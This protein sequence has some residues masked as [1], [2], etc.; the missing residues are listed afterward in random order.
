MQS[1]I[2]HGNRRLQICQPLILSTFAPPTWRAVPARGIAS[3]WNCL[4]GL[5]SL[6]DGFAQLNLHRLKSSCLQLPTHQTG[7]RHYTNASKPE[8]GLAA[9]A[10]VVTK[11]PE[12]ETTT[13][14]I[15]ITFNG[16]QAK[17]S[18]QAKLIR[19]NFSVRNRFKRAPRPAI[20]GASMTR[21]EP[22]LRKSGIPNYSEL[23]F[24]RMRSSPSIIIHALKRGRLTTK[25]RNFN[26]AAWS[27]ENSAT[28]K[29]VRHLLALK[30]AEIASLRTQAREAGAY[31]SNPDASSSGFK[32]N[33]LARLDKREYTNED[34]EQ[35]AKIALA[36]AKVRM[37]LYL[38]SNSAVPPQAIFN[39]ALRDTTP[40]VRTLR[41]L[42]TSSKLTL[43]FFSERRSLTEAGNMQDNQFI[44]I[45]S[46]LM[47]HARRIAPSMLPKSIAPLVIEYCKILQLQ[48]I[49]KVRLSHRLHKICNA[50]V[51]RL[52]ITP[53]RQPME[54]MEYA[55]VAQA[56]IL[57]LGD[58]FSPGLTLDAPTYRAII[59]V[60]LAC[61]KTDW[62][63]HAVTHLHRTWPPWRRTHDG[64][65]ARIQ[66]DDELS[67]VVSVV[68]NLIRA[69]HPKTSFDKMAMIL[70]GR[71]VDGTPTIPTRTLLKARYDKSAYDPASKN[72]DLEWA[73]R[74]RATRDIRE[75]WGA[76][77]AC[78]K[79][80]LKPTQ[81]M[82]EEMIEK[83][84]YDTKREGG[85]R[86]TPRIPGAGREVAIYRNDNLSE[87][88]LL[89]VNPPNV[90]ELLVLMKRNG[91]R[92]SEKSL[93]LLIRGA[94]SPRHAR[95]LMLQ[96]GVD[97]FAVLQL[98][99]GR[100]AQNL[101]SAADKEIIPERIMTAYIQLLCRF[102]AYKWVSPSQHSGRTDGKDYLLDAIHIL[103]RAPTY[104]VA[105][106]T[107]VK[108]I[109]LMKKSKRDETYDFSTSVR[110]WMLLHEV[111]QHR[112]TMN[113]VDEDT[114]GYACY[115]LYNAL[116]GTR[117]G[118]P[119][120]TGV[121][122]EGIAFINELW[123]YITDAPAE[124]RGDT[125][126][127]TLLHEIKGW[128]LHAYVRVLARA[129]Q[130]SQIASL[131]SWITHHE[132]ELDAIALNRSNG[133]TGLRR[134]LVAMRVYA[135]STRD[136]EFEGSL[137][138]MADSIP[139]DWGGWPTDGECDEYLDYTSEAEGMRDI[140][141]VRLGHG[142]IERGGEGMFSSAENIVTEE[143]SGPR[144]SVEPVGDGT[145][146]YRPM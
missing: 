25:A 78:E 16:R 85:A 8:D 60:L 28:A 66:P 128:Q 56:K 37:L 137:R 110:L 83:L 76:F 54:N 88:E 36:P 6:D 103:K 95:D 96:N 17:L 102:S 57:E 61:K 92:L 3:K 35:W 43:M 100:G 13:K 5:V 18:P 119:M 22:F 116:E 93:C 97:K 24:K 84:V 58:T 126:H 39:E 143:R 104:R 68:R 118:Y 65:D 86:P 40:D 12:G 79:L 42:I 82:F 53:E 7:T 140:E 109:A 108:T 15:G 113:V 59:K 48:E 121:K 142:I 105:W 31:I 34:I 141:G 145:V 29:L 1:R 123:S 50:A 81:G 130:K 122:N 44:T 144:N 69:G 129:G 32:E 87:T 139:Q 89:R 94:H 127:P 67:R 74:V 80:G 125:S 55:W 23:Q 27:K 134:T 38:N 99:R 120:E 136:S 124:E 132:N 4:H 11:A 9:P 90:D 64:M 41:K 106:H 138:D 131:L 46:T 45:F 111:L 14:S 52:A 91:V 77:R 33:F 70:G 19:K 26:F 114:F 117:Q 30:P 49:S 2:T 10:E 20:T 62:E 73:A 112:L 63:E 133:L 146:V 51:I 115:G 71:D 98:A 47:K 21:T 72:T 107:L 135:I 75:A 101:G